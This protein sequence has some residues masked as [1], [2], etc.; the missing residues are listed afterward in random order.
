MFP[1]LEHPIAKHQQ[2]LRP[3]DGFS[4]RPRQEPKAAQA[5]EK[6]ARTQP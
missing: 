1:L 3:L 5:V 6:R 2:H 4:R